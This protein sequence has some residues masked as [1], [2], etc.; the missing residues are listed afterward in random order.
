[1]K[2][3]LFIL[4]LNLSLFASSMDGVEE[5]YKQL[6][7][8]I[9]R[10]SLK[11]TPEEKVSLYFLVLTTHEKIMSALAV[12]ENKIE[13]LE[14]IEQKTLKVFANLHEKNTELEN[15]DIERLR[16]LYS[17]MNKNAL[18]SIK[19]NSVK[20]SDSKAQPQNNMLAYFIVAIL[21]L[22]VGALIGYVFF[23]SGAEKETKNTNDELFKDLQREYDNLLDEV[24]SLELQKESWHVTNEN[25]NTELKHE[26]A[27]LE[28]D[29]ESL[30][31]KI[32][33][34][35]N[36]QETLINE[37]QE[38]LKSLQKQKASLESQ[39]EAADAKE[40]S[41]EESDFEFDEKVNALQEQSQDIF[42][43]LETIS[44]IADQTNLLALNAAIE[45]ARAGEHG[46]GFAVVADEVRKLAERTQHTLNE[47]K[48]NISGVVDSISTLKS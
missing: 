25:S 8:E 1:M 34:L 30:K 32:Q 16:E 24:K 2:T 15:E 17:K 22:F 6:N 46:R 23:K 11:L 42:K 29:I 19:N 39:K 13:S 43:I 47:A 36:S 28:E 35:K 48:V 45:A 4:L 26:K 27:A 14:G 5:N 41:D 38:E 12:D 7:Q 21:A 10:V 9:D 40:I 3:V 37:F 31:T 18:E 44:D 33:E 20:T